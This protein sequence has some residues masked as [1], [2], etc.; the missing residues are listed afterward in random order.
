MI[1]ANII[2]LIVKIITNKSFT[3]NILTII[4]ILVIIYLI[5]SFITLIMIKKEKDY[6]GLSKK[7][8][9]KVILYNPLFLMGYIPCAIKALM[10]PN[11]AWKKIEHNK[12]I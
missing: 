10:N 7:M 11:M 1:I 8:K 12:N 9:I 2:I 4:T 6:F 5:L 3:L